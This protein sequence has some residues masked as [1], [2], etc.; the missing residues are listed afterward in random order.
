MSSTPVL[1]RA[2]SA[3]GKY[4]ANHPYLQQRSTNSK[5]CGRCLKQPGIN[6]HKVLGYV[7]ADCTGA[8]K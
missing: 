6:E 7:C 1:R 4:K 2:D 8:K 5:Q 3:I